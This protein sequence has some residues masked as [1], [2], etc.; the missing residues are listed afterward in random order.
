MFDTL[1]HKWV[2]KATKAA[3]AV[4][5][6]YVL[7]R[8]WI[9]EEIERLLPKV[10]HTVKTIERELPGKTITIVRRAAAD[11]LP[12]PSWVLHLPHRLHGIDELEERLGKRLR[13][14]EALLGATAMAAAMANVLGVSARCLRSGNVGKV[15]RAVCG[16]SR[17]AL[18]DLLGLLVDVLIVEDVC[19]VIVLLEDALSLVQGPLNDFVTVVDGALCHG[20]YGAAPD[21]PDVR[22]SLPPVTGLTLS[23]V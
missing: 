12:L 3:V 7:I 6:P 8:Q 5:L 2:P 19:Q 16:L 14:V 10:T 20:D 22:L 18:N 11:V 23:L 4:T 17:E 9:T 1:I 13:K 21:D 15:A